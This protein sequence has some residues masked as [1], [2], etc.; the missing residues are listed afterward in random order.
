MGTSSLIISNTTPLINFSGI[1]RLDILEKLFFK[2]SIPLAVQKEL[3]EKK[4][5]FPN[6]EFIFNSSFVSIQEIQ[7]EKIYK[8]LKID[9]DDGEAEAITI[10]IENN[11]EL[12]L[13]D[14]IAGRNQA[15]YHGLRF[16]GTIGCLVLAKKKGIIS[17]IKPFLDE[18]K[19]KSRFWINPDLYNKILKDYVEA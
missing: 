19:I 15:E 14:E 7:N 3:E 17:Y 2:I 10:A 1:D 6:I 12:L 13:L 18:M 5:L 9:L 4:G 16:T 11:A 8:S